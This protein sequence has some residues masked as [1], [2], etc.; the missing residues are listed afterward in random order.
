MSKITGY[1]PQEVF[2]LDESVEKILHLMKK[3]H[4]MIEKIL[5]N[6]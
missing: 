5:L 1:V 2:I 4:K 3:Y 6:F